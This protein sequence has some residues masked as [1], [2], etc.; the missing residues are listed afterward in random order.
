MHRA[1]VALMTSLFVGSLAACAPPHLSEASGSSAS[2]ESDP[3]S[4]PGNGGAASD[5]EASPGRPTCTAQRTVHVVAGTGGLAWFSLLW[6]APEVV[7]ANQPTFAY[8]DVARAPEAPGSSDEHPLFA[9]QVGDHVLWQSTGSSPMPTVFVAGTNQTHTSSP[10]T[11][12]LP[13]GADVIAA[14]AAAQAA[15]RAPIPVLRLGT[16]AQYGTATGAPPATDAADISAAIEQLRAMGISPK[17]VLPTD[18]KLATWVDPNAYPPLRAL[19]KSLLF[20]ANAMRV[21]AVGTVILPAFEDDPH[22]AFDSSLPSE[23]ADGLAQVLDAFYAELASIDEPSCVVD[24]HPIPLADNVV[25][26][27]SG[28]TPKN[29][30][31]RSWPDYTPGGS[32]QLYV[33]ANG[34]LKEGWFGRISSDGTRTNF[35]PQTGDLLPFAGF[36]DAASTTAA[37]DGLL[38]AITRG[39]G[40]AVATTDAST[41]DGTIAR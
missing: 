23:V 1:H 10:R 41:F 12:F 38:Y 20:T 13:S 24:G 16:R 15:L 35:D 17:A 30:F 26:V 3:G 7:T 39:D 21:G 27:V 2:S 33:R 14:G 29:A 5:V 22:G 31:D 36:V 25:F 19:A 4:A 8:D 34:F 37:L 32:N 28:D 40:A 9:R 11:T 6:P 18:E